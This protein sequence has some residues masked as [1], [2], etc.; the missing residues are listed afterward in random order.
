LTLTPEYV[1]R[2]EVFAATV[3]GEIVAFYA[4]I[5]QGAL[6]V[7]D[8]LWVKPDRIRSGIGRALWQHALERATARG[9]TRVE[10][11]AEPNAVGFYEKMGAFRIGERPVDF[12]RILP[13]MR[14][15]LKATG[16]C[17]ECRTVI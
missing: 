3:N 4:L 16:S 7:L 12:G 10:L 15:D 13:T 5:P 14:I 1:E 2:Y 8:H 11:E 9:A 17:P 6:A